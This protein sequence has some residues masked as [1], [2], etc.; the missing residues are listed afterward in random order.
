MIG[1]VCLGFAWVIAIIQSVLPTLGYY[2]NNPYLLAFARPALILQSIAIASAYFYLTQAF[3]TDDF[4]L[5]YVASHSHPALP[6]FYRMSALWSG[7]EGSLLLW[8]VCLNL[9]SLIFAHTQPNTAQRQ[10]TIAILGSLSAAFITI[11]LFSANPFIIL[12]HPMDAGDLTPLLQDPGN[13]IH[14]PMLT[15]GYVGFSLT[16]A[17]TIAA[18]LTNT[19][20]RVYAKTAR[21]LAL[22]AWCV[23]TLG[24]LLGS[25]WAYHVLG[26][27]GFWFWDPVENASLLPWL[28][29]LAFIH[30][31]LLMETKGIAIG[32]SATLALLTFTLSLLG[33]FLIRSGLLISP[34]AFASDPTRG[35]LF[36]SLLSIVSFA[37]LLLLVFKLP[38]SP[39]WRV[40]LGSRE[41]KL[42]IP[43]VILCM[44]VLAILSGTL[45]PVFRL[46]LGFQKVVVSPV[47]YNTLLQP[48]TGFLLAGLAFASPHIKLKKMGL[49]LIIS[50]CLTAL[51]LTKTQ[52]LTPMTF[53]LLSLAGL[54]I[55]ALTPHL[56][57]LPGMACAHLGF[58]ILILGI[59]LSS[60]YT[61][62]VT[63]HLKPGTAMQL[64]PYQV[65]FLDVQ[66]IKTPPV[67]RI[68]GVFDVISHQHT[69][70]VLTP[71]K[72]IYPRE[73]TIITK[74]AIDPGVFRDLY[75]VLG[76]PED[77]DRWTVRLTYK[78]FI[79][80]CVIGGALMIFGGILAVIQRRLYR[81]SH[82]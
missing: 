80:W 6:W 12:S 28:T 48:L 66:E 74:A 30:C 15:L 43:V 46:A 49:H 77:H 32:L 56:F 67:H 27:G 73:Q 5:V 75:L 45:Y 41:G 10:L 11:L 63:A 54:A 39:P 52:H 47:Y 31:I 81:N 33:T 19:L 3:L 59:V 78:P 1:I 4:S 29:G 2:R 58:V 26:W 82:D 62:T 20:N 71:E 44:M 55:M 72:R 61:V 50:M 69:V 42:L 40:N 36:F 37:A 64:G 79:R 7:Y 21:Q 68:I 8:V 57:S 22:L 70:A 18:L 25:W 24:I 34:H 38:A 65:F 51:L 13:L 14:P 23:L 35:I 53:L 17:L 16:F 60:L 76:D 9:W